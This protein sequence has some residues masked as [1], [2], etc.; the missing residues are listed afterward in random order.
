MSMWSSP[1]PTPGRLTGVD[2][3]QRRPSRPVAA[4]IDGYISTKRNPRSSSSLE[5][6]SPSKHVYFRKR[7]GKSTANIQS[8]RSPLK[9]DGS[10]GLGLKRTPRFSNSRGDVT[11]TTLSTVN[12]QS[13][14]FSNL[15]QRVVGGSAQRSSAS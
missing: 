5:R 7:R 1:S 14:P 3:T 2:F 6:S 11:S 12:A 9:P 10:S 13:R 15:Y 8:I 4:V